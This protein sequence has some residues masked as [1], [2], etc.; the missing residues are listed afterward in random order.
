MALKNQDFTHKDIK[1]ELN[2]GNVCYHSVQYLLPFHLLSKNLT[3]KSHKTVI[4]PVVVYW[5][6]TCSLTSK[7]EYR[8]RVLCRISGT[9]WKEET[10]GWTKL[11]MSSFII[12]I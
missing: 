12:C 3:L 2:S 1:S 4:L 10:Q 6:E 8:L 11:L 9:K 7:E 5:C